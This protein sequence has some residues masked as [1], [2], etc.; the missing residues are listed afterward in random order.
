MSTLKIEHISH[1]D[2]GTPDLS[3]DSSGHLNIVNGNLQMGGVTMLNTSTGAPLPLS[4]GAMTGVI[5]NFESTGIDDQATSNV[6]TILSNGSVG[7]GATGSARF[8]LSGTASAND[9]SSAMVFALGASTKLYLGASNATDNV[10]TG[11]SLGDTVL[12]SNGNNI[13]FSVDSGASSAVYIKSNGNVGIGTSNPG[14]GLELNL[15]SGDGLLINSADIATIK[16]KATGGAVANWGFATTNLAAGDFG[17]YRSNA[18]GG[19]PIT[20]GTAKMYFTSDGN[21]SINSTAP[22]LV[23]N[24]TTLTIGN[25]NG[26]G[27]GMLSLQSGWGNTTYGRMFTSSGV[28][29]I[30]NPQSNKLV[31]YT[32]NLDRLRIDEN[33]RAGWSPDGGSNFYII[34]GKDGSSSSNAALS[35]EEIKRTLGSRA[36][37]GYYWLITPS[38]GVARQW[39]CDMETDGGG[40]ILVGHHGDGQLAT[41][42][43][44]WF[45]ST[46]AGSFNAHSTG[47]F[48]G[49]GYWRTWGAEHV[50]IECRTDD[51]FFNNSAV[52]KVGF[53][54]GSSNNLPSSAAAYNL[55]TKTFKDW[56]WDIYN[57]PGYDPANYQNAIRDS[58][59]NGNASF[60]EHFVFSWSPRTTGS[61]GDD[62]SNGPYWQIG[63]H[64]DGIH[65]HYEESAG[66]NGVYGNGGFHVVSNE[67]AGWGGGGNRF[68][69]QRLFRYNDNSGTVNIWIR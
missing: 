15:A 25:S 26:G 41:N 12:R 61:P 30:G 63:S 14:A 66:G 9:L 1:L 2:N 39:W 16:M 42:P 65:Q 27:D 38:D 49:G 5:S 57:A 11:S 35:A 31:L 6:L 69:M 52:S 4:G 67:D 17:I 58:S 23:G 19:D 60:T 64:H 51:T 13:L 50:M 36:V 10:I 3:I 22:D 56:C 55:P 24:T 7:I 28:F 34:H 46:N 45:D 53:K 8:T 18:V 43:G 20:A 33:G 29:K 40:W 32:A 59:V 47:T 62:G 44:N 68:G 48:K 21:V 37:S 54:W